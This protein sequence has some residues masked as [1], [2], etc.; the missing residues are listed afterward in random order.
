MDGMPIR[1]VSGS[2]ISSFWLVE[3]GSWWTEKWWEHVRYMEEQPDTH[4][5]KTDPN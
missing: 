5:P 4:N 2:L 1:Q 3:R